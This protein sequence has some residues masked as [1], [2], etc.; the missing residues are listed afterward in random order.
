[1]AS[2]NKVILVGNLTRDPE[3]RTVG[4]GGAKVATFGL[5]VNDV[6]RDKAGNS[7]E[8]PVFVDVDVWDRQAENAA[9]YLRKGRTVL[10]EGRLQMDAWEKDGQ[11]RTK[12][13]IRASAVKFMAPPPQGQQQQPQQRA[14]Q[15]APADFPF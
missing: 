8:R 5:A 14:E 11:K 9:Q 2:F 3:L 15:D 6:Y 10:V 4:S 12:L 13:K 1:M 7:V